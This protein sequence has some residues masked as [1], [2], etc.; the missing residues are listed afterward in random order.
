MKKFLLISISCFLSLNASGIEKKQVT[1]NDTLPSSNIDIQETQDCIETGHPEPHS[2]GSSFSRNP[3]PA[4]INEKNGELI[5][6]YTLPRLSRDGPTTFVIESCSVSSDGKELTVLRQLL[7][8]PSGGIEKSVNF[9]KVKT[10][11]PY[12]FSVNG[13][14]Y[15]FEL[16]DSKIKSCNVFKLKQGQDQPTF[17]RKIYPTNRWV[18]G[19]FSPV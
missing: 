8:A 6:E 11:K 14:L 1:W 3:Y 17:L 18:Y 10:T 7:Y 13:R 2:I 19:I 15:I 5:I 16:C 9:Y 4:Y 12:Q